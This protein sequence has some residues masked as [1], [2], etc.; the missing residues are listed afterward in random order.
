MKA[1][2]YSIYTAALLVIFFILKIPSVFLAFSLPT[3]LLS[4][5]YT[6]IM[7]AV[8]CFIPRIHIPGTICL[9]QHI[10]GYAFSGAI[11]FLCI[12]FLLG[13]FLGNLNAT[14]YD[15]SPR[16]ILYNLVIL[17]PPICARELIR[18]YAIGT[19]WRKP[20][21]PMLKT[22]L[23]TIFIAFLDLN[24]AKAAVLNETE[25]IFIYMAKDI[26]PAFM[27]SILLSALVYYGGA[28]SGIIYSLGIA[29]FQRVFP[30]LPS[31]P[32]LADSALGIAFPVMFT[33]YI[34]EKYHL[35]YRDRIRQEQ[36]G[37]LA[38]GAALTL[39]VLFAWFVVGVFPIYP[40]VVLTGSMEPEIRPGDAIL[41][42][43]LKDEKELYQLKQGDVINFKRDK[44]TITHRILD[45]RR[46]EAG[47][48]SFQTKG[49][50]N[51]SADEELVHPN[52]INGM[53]TAVIPKIGMPIL[54]LK[55]QEPIPKGV[56]DQ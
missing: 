55:S 12:S 16:G 53:V 39:S 33:L 26:L 17:V 10:S 45:I 47:N 3:Y 19:I 27:K 9:R 28:S 37:M 1:D 54:V 20:K 11:I 51:Q 29:V 14:P 43:K 42:E 25:T 4:F 13:I 38:Y 21:Y 50:N 6:L 23:L 2:K 34:R 56:T 7:I 40:S 46:D 32:W 22:A 18:T 31:L 8:I 44:I 52:N 30:F 36:G 48:L 5:F 24:L 41:I 49:D 15:I 35:L